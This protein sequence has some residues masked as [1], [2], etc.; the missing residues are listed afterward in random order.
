MRIEKNTEKRNCWT[1]EKCRKWDV[2]QQK[3]TIA[4]I[5]EI[6][7]ENTTFWGW[8]QPTPNSEEE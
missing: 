2:W 5:G 6:L 8:G 3:N 4:F 1:V 7:Q